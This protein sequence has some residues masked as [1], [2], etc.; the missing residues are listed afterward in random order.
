MRPRWRLRFL[1]LLAL[2]PPL[3]LSA[4]PYPACAPGLAPAVPSSNWL[5]S[6]PL[7]GGGVG[8]GGAAAAFPL[9]AYVGASGP[10]L[11]LY[12]GSD[13]LLALPG[14]NRVV[15]WR[16]A[17]GAMLPVAGTGYACS[18]G[19]GG[20]A[21]LATLNSPTGV[22]ADAAGN[23]YISDTASN[24]VRVI[25]ATSG[26]ITTAAGFASTSVY[27]FVNGAALTAR[28]RTPKTLSWDEAAQALY[29]SDTTN[30]CIRRLQGGLVT[31]AAGSGV[32][33]GMGA[34]PA[35]ALQAT[36]HQ[37]TVA[38]GSMGA[39][40]VMDGL[41]FR[42]RYTN[43]SIANSTLSTVAGNGTA[44]LSNGACAPAGGGCTMNTIF[45]STASVSP[46]S[47]ALFFA[48]TTNC[49]L[50][51]LSCSAGAPPS[52]ATCAASTLAGTGSCTPHSGNGVPA[53][54]SNVGR[55]VAVVAANDSWVAYSDPMSGFSRVRVIS[56]GL[57][58]D[59]IGGA[60]APGV[61]VY[62][63]D[64]RMPA[65]QCG[66][67]APS[68]LAAAGDALLLISDSA[69]CCVRA[70]NRSTGNL[71]VFAGSCGACGYVA[72][73][74]AAYQANLRT[75]KGIALGVDGTVFV[76]DAGNS[77]L[78]AVSPTGVL[79]NVAGNSSAAT[80][81]DG[82]STAPGAALNVPTGLA[83]L[84][85]Q[86]LAAPPL[87]FFTEVG[88]HRAR[89]LNLSSAPSILTVAG[90]GLAGYAGDGGPGPAG[91]LSAP[92][93]IAAVNS[94]SSS[95]SGASLYGTAAG[96]GVYVLIADTGNSAL[97][98]VLP[99]GTLVTLLGANSTPPT[100]ALSAPSAVAVSLAG[101]AS[102]YVADTGFN[103][104]VALRGSGAF[105]VLLG[106][107]GGTCGDGGTL[108]A[109]A[110]ALAPAALAIDPCSGALFFADALGQVRA[111]TSP[112]ASPSPT[113][114]PTS[115]RSPSRS[116][117]PSPSPVLFAGCPGG[118]AP[119]PPSVFAASGALDLYTPPPGLVA[120][121]ASLWGA[122]GGGGQF[123]G[124]T[125]GGG[126]FVSGWFS[127][128]SLAALTAPG[129]ALL[130]MVGGG[131]TY[132]MVPPSA[133][134][135]LGGIAYTS[136]GV[137][138]CSSG[139]AGASAVGLRGATPVAVAGAGGTAGQAINC[140]GV[141]AT[142]DASGVLPQCTQ[143]GP[144]G[145]AF[146]G[147]SGS[148]VAGGAPGC[149]CGAACPANG[150]ASAGIGPLVLPF[151]LSTGGVGAPCGG[152]GGGGYYGGGGGGEFFCLLCGAG[153]GAF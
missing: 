49:R 68:A 50:R 143:F 26:L 75:V 112:S 59:L 48:D 91:R 28:F 98:A 110:N 127:T 148:L 85:P 72:G 52:A 31:T 123:P 78:R 86:T 4:Q 121:F 92:A 65:S 107:P 58:R 24:A 149:G 23:V 36:L 125:G 87:L 118:S 147:Q 55:V 102:V 76:A 3:P 84:L 145:L 41:K 43:A 142:W 8:L 99:N 129:A 53:A 120:L 105:A 146:A 111:L 114:T 14:I 153:G 136:N 139:G 108:A 140:A 88:S 12:N 6:G 29:I 109:S 34:D 62:V 135:P 95:S 126:A 2:L 116:P 66:L 74:P 151:L 96:A 67:A 33:V 47:G 113:P 18:A 39:M 35:A 90:N 71:T 13:L 152:H 56:G 133:L 51:V 57:A 64:G 60:A 122:G 138:S 45:S 103:R 100:L 40:W 10:Q 70:L 82:N 97:R 80:G 101:D 117:S 32:Y 5:V 16:A 128:A 93:A 134:P 25:S 119:A 131:A 73:G 44:G 19:D 69:H 1:L 132:G 27:G 137:N 104:I 81:P 15:R 42:I 94:S 144:Q 79:Y 61:P 37:P 21:A 17:D 106:S 46:Q 11:A 7:A 30:N 130:V 89:L 124:A 77:R 38:M 54:A 63:G 115:S 141:A 20:P 9:S 83:L 22:A 150:S